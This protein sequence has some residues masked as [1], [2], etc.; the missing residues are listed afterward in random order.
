MPTPTIVGGHVLPPAASTQS[1]TNVRIAST[2]SAGTAIFRNELFS[3]PLPFGIISISSVS[4]A[5]MKSM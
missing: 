5:A 2:P 1:T 3:D 4:G